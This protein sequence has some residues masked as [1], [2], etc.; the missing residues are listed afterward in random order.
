M[1]IKGKVCEYKLLT[2][3]LFEVWTNDKKCLHDIYIR[4]INLLSYDINFVSFYNTPCLTKCIA[5]L[6]KAVSSV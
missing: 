2:L 5:Y 3:I 4:D 6:F 1:N